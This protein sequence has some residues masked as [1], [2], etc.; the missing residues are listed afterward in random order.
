[1]LAAD[2]IILLRSRTR[3]HLLLVCV[4]VLME[5]QHRGALWSR[6]LLLLALQLLDL[7][8]PPLDLRPL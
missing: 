4:V 7:R 5:G 8:R 2:A 6:V 1:M 3:L